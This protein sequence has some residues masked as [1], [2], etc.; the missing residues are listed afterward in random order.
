MRFFTFDEFRS[1]AN[2]YD[3][4]EQ[5]DEARKLVGGEFTMASSHE[6]ILLHL[7]SE[8]V[9]RKG[10]CK[11]L[12]IGTFDGLNS[13]L[14]VTACDALSIV[15][16]DILPVDSRSMGIYGDFRRHSRTEW[17]KV[18]YSKRIA[19][20][21]HP[22]IQYIEKSS[23]LLNDVA[24]FQNLGQIDIFWI[25]GDHGF[26][27]VAFDA[28]AAITSLSLNQ[29]QIIVLD[30]VHRSDDNPSMQV[31]TSLCRD[32]GLKC[33]MVQKRVGSKPDKYVA[34]LSMNTLVD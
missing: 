12:E 4:Q 18:H 25:D 5:V 34:V 30:D 31:I 8:V 22:R 29:Q 2:A 14:L 17:A 26:P 13:R 28:A 24:Q 9:K 3:C 11:L 10:H 7:S 20:T 19:N 15:T 21:T 32:L 6:A 16:I 23:T 33:F 27:Q 1:A